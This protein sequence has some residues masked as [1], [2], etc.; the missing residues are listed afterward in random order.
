[1]GFR[2]VPVS[3]DRLVSA[4]ISSELFLPGE[5][6]SPARAVARGPVARSD[7]GE[8]P[9]GASPAGWSWTSRPGSHR[10]L[11]LPRTTLARFADSPVRA[12]AGRGSTLRTG[13]GTNRADRAG[14]GAGDG[15]E[16]WC[17]E[18]PRRGPGAS[19]GVPG[20]SRVRP[21]G[22]AGAGRGRG[23]P[24]AVAEG[25]LSRTCGCRG[26]PSSSWDGGASAACLLGGAGRGRRSRPG[27]GGG[28][29]EPARS[30][31]RVSR[32]LSV[33]SSSAARCG[34]CA[35]IPG[36]AGASGTRTSAEWSGV[37][38]VWSQRASM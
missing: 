16:H 28:Q 36:G 33:E 27:P 7:Y 8:P 6:A 15:S 26:A 14:H 3:P 24:R 23:L 22:G 20:A 9:G 34:R 32:R 10:L 4:W 1:M 21:G 2:R 29:A 37:V 31:A 12:P 19:R 25:P 17:R 5:D 18:R 35:A 30:G 13:A 38:S 11:S